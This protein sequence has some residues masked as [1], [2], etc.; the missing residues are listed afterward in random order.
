MH[1]NL[2]NNPMQFLSMWG[3][4]YVSNDNECSALKSKTTTQI[5]VNTIRKRANE[6]KLE[7]VH[8]NMCDSVVLREVRD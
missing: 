7:I 2:P 4:I 5:A 6:F 3:R 1:K 8:A